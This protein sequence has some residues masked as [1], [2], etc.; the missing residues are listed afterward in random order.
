MELLIDVPA[1]SVATFGGRLG[2]AE[3]F[4][5]S[6]SSARK[7]LPDWKME[8]DD[9]PI[10]RYVYHH[11]QPRRHLEF[12]TWQ[13]AGVVSCLESCNATVWAI[14]LPGG[15]TEADGRWAYADN[16]PLAEPLPAG[17]KTR[18]L[19]ENRHTVQTDAYSFI[20]HVYL[21]RG[22]G[23]R[24]CQIYADSR[25]WDIANYPPGFFDS[26]LI[27]GGH[28]EEVVA[29]DLHKAMTLVRAGGL[30]I[31]HDFCPVEDVST[32]CPSTAGV[33]AAVSREM[34][35]LRGSLSDLFWI[36]PSWLL[37]GVRR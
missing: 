18:P 7:S 17:A 31:L 22:L 33:L 28:D 23:H 24:V 36:K 37:V 4:C 13:G 1:E 30:V 11:A 29:G 6:E 8:E 19:D 34:P 27:D 14:N 12:G 16:R 26:S 35:Y 25:D 20:G 21:S 2:F 10:L 5:I 9:A 3:P 15:E 32:A